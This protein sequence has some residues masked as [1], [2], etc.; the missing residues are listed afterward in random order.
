MGVDAGIRP[1]LG[2]GG[3]LFPS[4]EFHV[5]LYGVAGRSDA[6]A[7]DVLAVDCL[8]SAAAERISRSG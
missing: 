3:C 6:A 7:T 1:T 8:D 2:L 4:Q 5:D